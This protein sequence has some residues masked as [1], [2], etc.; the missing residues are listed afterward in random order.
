MIDHDAT[1]IRKSVLSQVCIVEETWKNHMREQQAMS[2]RIFQSMMERDQVY[3]VMF[4]SMRERDRVYDV[5]FQENTR[6]MR[7]RERAW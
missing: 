4:K 5:M 3:D 6:W 1:P 2:E 7:F